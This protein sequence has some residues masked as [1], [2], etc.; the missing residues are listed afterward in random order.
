MFVGG[1]CLG[2][3]AVRRGIELDGSPG[4]TKKTASVRRRRCLGDE[5][6]L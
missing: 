3:S 2:V 4:V 5:G 6:R 1:C